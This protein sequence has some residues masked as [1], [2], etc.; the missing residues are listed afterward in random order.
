MFALVDPNTNLSNLIIRFGTFVLLK[1]RISWNYKFLP[2]ILILKKSLE[3]N[4]AIKDL[5][6]FK[7]VIY[8]Q[9]LFVKL[10]KRNRR[11]LCQIVSNCLMAIPWDCVKSL[12]DSHR[13]VQMNITV[14][15]FYSLLVFVR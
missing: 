15:G 2:A 12:L 9:Y 5:K 6:T 3:E 13:S 14:L 1:A 8:I 11:N 7:V 4:L 10:N